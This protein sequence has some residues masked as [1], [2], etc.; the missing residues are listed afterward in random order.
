MATSKKDVKVNSKPAGTSSMASAAPSISGSRPARPSK[1]HG[2]AIR[3]RTF[4]H[5]TIGGVFK[6]K[7][8]QEVKEGD[9]HDWDIFWCDVG[10]MK[11]S[12]DQ[13]YLEEHQRVCHFRNHYEISRKNLM[14]RNLKRLK[15][16]LEKESKIEAAKCDFFP[17][18]YELPSEYHM[19]VEEFKRNPGT[20]WIMK[21]AGKAQG[22]GIFLFRKLKDITDWKKEDYFH[23]DRDEERN[24]RDPPETYV[25][26]RYIEKPY[27]IG[28]KK[29]DIRVY[30]LVM[31]YMPLKVWLYRSGFARFSNARFSLNSITNTF[32]HLTN[33]AIQKTAP[34]YDPEKGCK[35]SL[36]EFRMF[37]TAKHG[38]VVV[39]RLFQEIDG[40]I[41]KSLQS[42]QKIIINDKHCFELYGF[43]VMFDEDLKPWLIEVNASPSLT[44]SSKLDFDLK[45]GLLQDMLYIVDMEGERTGSEKRVGGFDLIWNDGPV[46]SDELSLHCGQPVTYSSNSFLGCYND[47]EQQL[48]Q[49]TKTSPI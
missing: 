22:K 12:F 28:G 25:V 13:C 45:F 8:W 10:W 49:M 40:I 39:R 1:I 16:Q 29:F 20:I 19:F 4:L 43:D 17:T 31:S 36:Q 15:R 24:E 32:V 42:V 34:D 5:N 21:P 7:G 30:V 14:A 47:R 46:A 9:P 18:T 41:I 33:V 48:E 26:Q 27:L 35:W 37:L 2:R 11:D 38:H 6:S 3:Y 23:R 44:A